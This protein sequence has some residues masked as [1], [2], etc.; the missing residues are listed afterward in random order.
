MRHQP[1]KDPFSGKIACKM[2]GKEF[3]LLGD[4][5]QN[6]IDQLYLEDCSGKKELH[7]WGPAPGER[8]FTLPPVCSRC[9]KSS[10]DV[11]AHSACQGAPL[12]EAAEPQGGRTLTDALRDTIEVQAAAALNQTPVE[13]EISDGR[14]LDLR[15]AADLADAGGLG[16]VAGMVIVPTRELR[17][18]LDAYETLV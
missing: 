8:G 5:G 1:Q 13:R 18:L 11:H 10:G 7:R 17:V 9:G 12:S 6:T 4:G 16:V 15:K 3:D 14:L 2:C